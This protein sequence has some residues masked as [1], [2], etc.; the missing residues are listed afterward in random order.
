MPTDTSLTQ[1]ELDIQDRTRAALVGISE[2]HAALRAAQRQRAAAED[3]WTALVELG[4]PGFLISER[5]GGSD[6]GLLPA[7][8]VVEELAAHSLHSFQPILLTMAASAISAFGSEA[9]KE[10]FLPPMAR[11][12]LKV[13][14]ASTERE[15][16]FNV[17]NTTTVARRDGDHFVVNGA[18]TYVSGADIANQML[19]VTRTTS[20]EERERRQLLR[21]AGLTLLFADAQATG[22]AITPQPTR[23]EAVLRQFAME[24]RDV[25]V[26]AN[27]VVGEVDDGVRV[28]FRA[29][30]PERTLAA[31]L[32]LGIVRHCLDRACAHARSRKVF[33]DVAIGAYQ[34]I[35]HPLAD[36]AIRLD[37]ARALTLRAAREFDAGADAN[38]VAASAAAAKYLAS[39][40]AA[41]AVDAAIST[42]GGKGFDEDYGVIHLWEQA[43]LLTTAPISNALILNQIAQ[44]QLRLPRSY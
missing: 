12:A 23:G 30:N 37:A 34:S 11:G 19:L 39:G 18:K 4:F 2:R 44:H 32:G 13:A 10:T 29:F 33:D 24:L 22:V 28:M 20:R 31:A 14:I 26:P 3:V 6:R 1:R 25:R 27:C 9:L 7:A 38:V 15:A 5:Y 8:L 17:L 36:L 41:S 40:L 35:Q 43:R 42:L 16:G 21:T